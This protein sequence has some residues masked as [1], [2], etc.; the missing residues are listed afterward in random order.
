MASTVRQCGPRDWDAG[1]FFR[2]ADAAVAHGIAD[3]HIVGA[4]ALAKR[5][6]QK[7]SLLLIGHQRDRI[8]EQRQVEKLG[9]P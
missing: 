5:Q 4:Q 8:A 2:G 7:A 6:L 3:V 9:G 1:A